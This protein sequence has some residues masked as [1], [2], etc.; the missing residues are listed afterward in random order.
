MLP[1]VLVAAAIDKS[2]L[3]W[4]LWWRLAWGLAAVCLA[5]SSN[6]VLNELLDARTD[7]V[8]PVKRSR[9]VPAGKAL[10]GLA[11]AQWAAF[12]AAGIWLGA[13]LD[14]RLGIV[15]GVFCGMACLYNIPPVRAKDWPFADV[16]ME[17]FNNPLRMLA[18]W[19][20]TGTQTMPVF[21]LLMSYWMAGCYFMAVKR[22]AEYRMIGDPGR[23][24]AYRRSFAWYTEPR[25]LAAIM[26][27]A[28][29]SMLFFGAFL[30]RY[31]LELV[32][33]YPLVA[34]V[35][36]VYLGMAFE[37]DSP[38]QCPERLHRYPL[39][40]AAVT[41]C[42]ALMTGLTFIDL[43]WLHALFQPTVGPGLR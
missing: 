22:L 4:D 34:A 12:G 10:P 21:S 20:L 40:M 35:M 31:R 43:P 32:L 26:F 18:G 11:W 3:S 24:A 36:A 37:P 13:A 6:Y 8:H 38:A 30:M 19:Y 39:L 23:S 14:W 1:G 28:A 15:L 27:Y 9:A 17:G 2:I 42:A 25:L 29:C 16:L 5:A 41:V 7:A 33:S